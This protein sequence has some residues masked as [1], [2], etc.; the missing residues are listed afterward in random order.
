MLNRSPRL[1]ARRAS[2][3]AAP[4]ATRPRSSP[5]SPAAMDRLGEAAIREFGGFE[6]R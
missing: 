3:Y 1:S 4:A 6:R 5:M 2:R